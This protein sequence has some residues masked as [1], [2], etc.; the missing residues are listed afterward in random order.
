VLSLFRIVESCCLIGA[1]AGALD[2]DGIGAEDFGPEDW[3]SVVEFHIAPSLRFYRHDRACSLV[4]SDEG[5]PPYFDFRA[6]AIHRD[7][8][9]VE[10]T[11]S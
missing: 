4:E 10:L 11:N 7:K 9:V 5:H 6:N 2:A 3:R 1:S 8:K